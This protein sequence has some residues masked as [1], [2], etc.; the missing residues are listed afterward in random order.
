MGA[1]TVV[2][3]LAPS[4]QIFANR[5]T[6]IGYAV[7]V[8]GRLDLD[9]LSEAYAAVCRMYPVMA[10]HLEPDGNGRHLLVESSGSVPELSVVVGDPEQ[11]TAGA[12]VDQSLALSGLCVVR[13]GDTASVTLLTHHGAAD[14]SHSLAV[15]ARLWSFYTEIV[16]GRT[17]EVQVCPFPAPV[18]QLLATRGIAKKATA[19]LPDLPPNGTSST[20]TPGAPDQ[21]VLGLDEAGLLMFRTTRYRFTPETTAAVV[22]LG[23]RRNVTVNSLV[24]AAMLLTEAEL[25]ALTL[26]EL[27]Y[28]YPVDLRTRITPPIGPVE[29]TTVVGTN[30]YIPTGAVGNEFLGIARN[31]GEQLV[32]GLRSGDIQQTPLHIPDTPAAA[33]PPPPAGLFGSTNWG[34]VP[35]PRSPDGLRMNDFRSA[36]IVRLAPGTRTLPDQFGIVSYTVSTFGG[37]LSVE[38]HHADETSAQHVHRMNTFAAT[39]QAAV[40]VNSP[41]I[42]RIP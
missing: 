10:A 32:D 35:T 27:F 11:L 3:P 29:G 13:D 22:D 28:A 4:E 33:P 23:R 34:R 2:R 37:R 41:S 25:R 20:T 30:L 39:L 1:G 6:Y 38:I 24:S 21:N 14:S 5:E 31:I 36:M 17:P 9:A 15:L 19:P 18:E 7:Q 26:P 16:A 40:A 8:S 12:K 42:R